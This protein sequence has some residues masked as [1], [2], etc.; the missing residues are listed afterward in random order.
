[1]NLYASAEEGQ[2]EMRDYALAEITRLLHKVDL[3]VGDSEF[4]AIQN[5]EFFERHADQFPVE[6]EAIRYERR[7]AAAAPPE[8]EEV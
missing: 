7:G 2:V 8:D 3:A 4:I 5:V 6:A 1:M